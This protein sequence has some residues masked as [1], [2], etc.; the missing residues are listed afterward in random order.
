MFIDFEKM[1]INSRIWIYQADRK[2]TANESNKA[3]YFIKS[4]IEGWGAHG[5]PLSA[6]FKI[7][8]DR[9]VVIALDENVAQAS[10]CSIDA[11]THWLKQLGE[12]Y[13]INFFDRSLAYF[14]NKEIKTVSVFQLKKAVEEGVLKSDTIVFNNTA[15]KYTD[16]INKW[17]VRADSFAYTSKFFKAIAV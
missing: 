15:T 4:E 10:G 3:S 13:G 6:S 12:E 2:L 14:E 1:P 5:T 8:Y 16:L 17:K 9:F 11:S 7:E